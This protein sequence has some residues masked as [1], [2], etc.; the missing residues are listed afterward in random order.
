MTYT[1]SDEIAYVFIAEVKMGSCKAA[2]VNCNMILKQ[3][4]LRF[5]VAEAVS[6]NENMRKQ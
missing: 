2:P 6:E 5:S 4:A 3:I 1:D